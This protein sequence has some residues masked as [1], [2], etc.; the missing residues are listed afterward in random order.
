V[1][2]VA[3]AEGLPA[4]SGR[5]AQRITAA[6]LATKGRRCHLC[7]TPDVATTADHLTPRSKGGDDSM[8]NLMP[9]CESCNKSRQAMPLGQWRAKHP[10]QQKGTVPM[11]SR[12]QQ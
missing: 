2:T 11:S 8:D 10:R 3:A 7:G 12:W 9:A 6:V 1:T 4:W 5:Y